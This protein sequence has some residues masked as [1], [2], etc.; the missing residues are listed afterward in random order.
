METRIIV[1]GIIQ[2]DEQIL[3]GKK[4][5]G[6]PPYPDVWHTIGGG[7]YEIEKGMQLISSEDY[8]NLYFHNELKR[9]LLEE[10]NISI[11][12]I[13]CII[14]RYRQ[15]PREAVTKNKDGEDTHYIFLEYFCELDSG[16]PAPGDDIAELLWINRKELENINLTPPSQEMYKELRWLNN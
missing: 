5:K 1:A 16:N 6:Q 9:E 4:T 7:I 12:N 3:L 13:S 10:A 8:D 15:N 14:P 2:N 11:K